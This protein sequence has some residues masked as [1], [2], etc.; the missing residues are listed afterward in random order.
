MEPAQAFL[1]SGHGL[2]KPG[3]SCRNGLRE[4]ETQGIFMGNKWWRLAQFMACR[5]APNV[6][7]S[8]YYWAIGFL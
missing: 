8:T 2:D 5:A 6:L 4:A 7:V 1:S 3:S